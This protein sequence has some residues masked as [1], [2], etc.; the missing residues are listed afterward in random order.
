[1][2][3]NS[4]VLSIG[5]TRAFKRVEKLQAQ[6]RI[7][8]LK[9]EALCHHS[10]WSTGTSYHECLVCGASDHDTDEERFQRWLAYKESLI[11]KTDMQA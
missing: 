4:Y 9:L 3:T 11:A 6:L 2:S 8:K 1:M 5:A 7:A 10:A